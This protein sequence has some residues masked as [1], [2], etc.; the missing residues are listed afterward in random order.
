MPP[1]AGAWR[2]ADGVDD[3]VS[4]RQ[5]R[6][7]LRHVE[8]S[9]GLSRAVIDGLVEAG[10]VT[11]ERGPRNQRRFSFQ[12]LMLLR[13]AHELRE[14]RVTPRRIVEALGKLRAALPEGTALT[15]V[16]VSALGSRVIVRDREGTR[17]ATSG[18]F[19]MDFDSPAAPAAPAAP[20]VTAVTA[21]QATR[22]SATV[23][24]LARADA[25]RSSA[26]RHAANDDASP[27]PATSTAYERAVALEATD[28]AAA[29]AE[30]R[31][32]LAADPSHLQA[33]INLAALLC[34]QGRAAQADAV[35]IAT[36]A[37][38]IDDALLRFNHAL[39]LDDLKRPRAALAAYQRAL[40][41]DPSF[42]DAHYNAACL[43]ESMHDARGALRHF[44]A[45]RKLQG[46]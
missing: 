25:R 9:L 38:G 18:Q 7:S 27:D 39:A 33:A 19:V 45:Y 32:A 26:E 24:E 2:P 14:A 34:D 8:Q 21:T 46:V 6:Y 44:A 16:R 10:F 17:D 29:E 1:G 22:P 43:L 37:T 13:T 31:R 4:S 35:C 30:Y 11:P 3:D 28:A 42:A 41:L 40:E 20:T 23:F 5:E 36:L 15:G 12:D